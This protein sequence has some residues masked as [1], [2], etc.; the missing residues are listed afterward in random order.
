MTKANHHPKRGHISPYKFSL[1]KEM[2]DYWGVS[3][4]LCDAV[5]Y[6]V[7]T[8]KHYINSYKLLYID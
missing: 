4:Q 5:Y 7:K 8:L 6:N 2:A 1:K 3:P